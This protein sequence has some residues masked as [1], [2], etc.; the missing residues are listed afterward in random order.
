MEFLDIN[1]G[2]TEVFLVEQLPVAVI[3]GPL[4]QSSP[5]S[6]S[7]SCRSSN[8]HTVKA[9]HVVEKHQS[10]TLDTMV[11]VQYTVCVTVVGFINLQSSSQNNTVNL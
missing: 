1:Q 3:R 10:P 8:C 2:Y 7:K 9:Q 6:I 11:K 4:K 5:N